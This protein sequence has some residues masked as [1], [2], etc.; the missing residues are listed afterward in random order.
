MSEEEVV[1]YG[2]SG[3]QAPA[4]PPEPGPGFLE[5]VPPLA[6]WILAP[7]MLGAAFYILW[8][9][10][11]GRKSDIAKDAVR[12]E[13]RVRL[14]DSQSTGDG[15]MIWSVTFIYPDEQKRNHEAT[16]YLFDEGAW[17]KLKPEAYVKVHYVPGQPGMAFMD[18]AQA[19][20]LDTGGGGKRIINILPPNAG[21]LSFLGWSL[22]WASLPV[23]V[24]AYLASRTERKPRP[25]GPKV[26]MTRR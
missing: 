20:A 19:I 11:P 15:R 21:A 10:I 23:F 7:L 6:L 4:P 17:E 16:N 9:F 2:P 13:A 26:V 1:I 3:E 12:T 24:L 22:L 5:R 25:K 8:I 14:K 18:T